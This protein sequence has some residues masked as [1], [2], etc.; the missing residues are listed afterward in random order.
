MRRFCSNIGWLYT[1]LVASNS[2]SPL[3]REVAEEY[4]GPDNET[5]ALSP[6]HVRL[7]S[8]IKEFM[9]MCVFPEFSTGICSRYDF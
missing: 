8:S 7:S 4:E 2:Y 5:Q 1:R 3:S 9:A 6:E